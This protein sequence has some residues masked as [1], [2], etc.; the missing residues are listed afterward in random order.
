MFKF[1][2]TA[3]FAIALFTFGVAATDPNRVCYDYWDK[4]QLDFCPTSTI[5]KAALP[6][7]IMWPLYWS[8]EAA[9]QVRKL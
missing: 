2:A 6:A 8:W 1:I 4:V 5:V 3:Y 9:E 7:A